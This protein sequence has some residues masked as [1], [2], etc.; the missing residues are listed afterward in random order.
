MLDFLSTFGPHHQSLKGMPRIFYCSFVVTLLNFDAF[1]LAAHSNGCQVC[2]S[3]ALFF[4]PWIGTEYDAVARHECVWSLVEGRCLQIQV[5][6]LFQLKNSGSP[7]DMFMYNRI[8][9]Y[10]Y[11][12]T[13]YILYDYVYVIIIYNLFKILSRM[14]CFHVPYQP[15][16]QFQPSWYQEILQRSLVEHTFLQTVN[17]QGTFLGVE[18]IIAVAGWLMEAQ[19]FINGRDFPSFFSGTPLKVHIDIKNDGL[20]NVFPALVMVI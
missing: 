10:R 4:S 7:V 12:Y 13:V 2:W 20:E 6:L 3:I 5:R 18:N 9:A 17:V 14:R 11:V 16:H 19:Q 1:T 15:L 8:S